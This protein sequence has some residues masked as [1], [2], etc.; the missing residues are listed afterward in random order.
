MT[1]AQLTDGRLSPSD[2]IDAPLWWHEQGLM[3]NATGYG[4]KLTTRRKILYGGRLY[5][6]YCTIYSNSGTCWICVKGEKIF[7]WDV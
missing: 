4:A 7:F 2:T 1:D 5:R 6:V 3:E